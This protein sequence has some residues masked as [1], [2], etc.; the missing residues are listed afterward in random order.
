MRTLWSNSQM[1]VLH[2][3]CFGLI[4]TIVVPGF[5][6][7]VHLIGIILLIISMY[8][9]LALLQKSRSIFLRYEL[10]ASSEDVERLHYCVL[11]HCIKCFQEFIVPNSRT[12]IIDYSS[13]LSPLVAG[14]L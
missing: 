7:I 3:L 2:K 11:L 6:F 1:A 10:I 13:A 14:F 9:V 5:I 12:T 4:V 8:V